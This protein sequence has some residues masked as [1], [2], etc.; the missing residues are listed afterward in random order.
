M[1]SPE[2]KADRGAAIQAAIDHFKSLPVTEQARILREQA[3]NYA[4]N[5][6]PGPRQAQPVGP[7]TYF[8]ASQIVQ[9]NDRLR[10]ENAKLRG[11][12]QRLE[13]DAASMRRIM[14]STVESLEQTAGLLSRHV[15]DRDENL[16]V[17][18]DHD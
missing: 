5:Y 13:D 18:A 9:E 16:P 1:T 10:E 17:N 12:I 11:I 7:R 15:G 6:S 8:N 14:F 4:K 2:D 3:D